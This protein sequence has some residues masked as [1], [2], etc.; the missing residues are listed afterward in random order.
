MTIKRKINGKTVKIQLTPSEMREAYLE[1]ELDNYS[2][3]II[4]KLGE[5]VENGDV[6]LKPAQ[7]K[8]IPRKKLKAFALETAQQLDHDIGK[9]DSYFDAF[10]C[11]VETVLTEKIDWKT[12]LPK[13]LGT[14]ETVKEGT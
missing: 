3:D 1:E 5:L 11:S 10:W 6:P 4:G 13:L 8:K 2:E 7:L 12:T 9:N 14:V